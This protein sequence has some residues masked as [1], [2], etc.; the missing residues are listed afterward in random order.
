MKRDGTL[1]F[2]PVDHPD[3]RVQRVGFDLTD[4]YVEQCWSAVVGPSSTLLLRRLP[5]LWVTQVPA[6]IDARE[7][8]Q[9][10]GLGTGVGAHSRLNTTLQRLARYGLARPVSDG[11]GLDVYLQVA[12]LN[13][14]QVARLPQWTRDAHERLFGAHLDQIDHLARH[15]A[16]V[17]SIT[18]RLDRLQHGA[19]HATNSLPPH[20]QTLDR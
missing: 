19:G 12:P 6:E 4:P 15:H 8:S 13:E 3:A 20:G 1:S 5:A 10:L 16:N 9:S 18:A 17:E 11:S 14:R 2:T 7:L